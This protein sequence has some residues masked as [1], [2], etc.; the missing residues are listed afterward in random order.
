MDK[1]DKR[2]MDLTKTIAKWSS[3]YKENRNIGAIVVKNKRILTTGYTRCPLGNK[4]LQRER[5]MSSSEIKYPLRQTARVM[6]CY[7][8]RTKRNYTGRQA[9]RQY[10]R[11][12]PILHPPAM[13]HLFQDDSQRRDNKGH[14]RK[15]IPRRLY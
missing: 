9:G 7:T 5:R 8:R 10:R 11:L 13:R 15:T 3:C 1:W 4:K 12:H 14:I 2:F 6:L